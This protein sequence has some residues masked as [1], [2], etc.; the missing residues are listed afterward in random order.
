MIVQPYEDKDN[1]GAAQV[2]GRVL[3]VGDWIER[4]EAGRTDGILGCGQR[5]RIAKGGVGDSASVRLSE[6][7]EWSERGCG[8]ERRRSGGSGVRLTRRGAGVA[9]RVVYETKL[10]RQAPV[11]GPR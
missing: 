10:F 11:P 8:S 4:L 2:Q 1:T 9:S 6:R 7:G 3:D 5:G